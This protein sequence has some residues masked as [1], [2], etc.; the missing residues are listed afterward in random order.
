MAYYIFLRLYQRVSKY[1]YG[2]RPRTNNMTKP[3]TKPPSP[4]K[5]NAPLGG[6]I[7]SFGLSLASRQD[8]TE[9]GQWLQNKLHAYF[10]TGL[11]PGDMDGATGPDRDGER[12]RELFAH[13]SVLRDLL[14]RLGW[15]AGKAIK[16]SNYQ[17]KAL[18]LNI[19]SRAHHLLNI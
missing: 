3:A 10:V 14:D 18:A 4:P 17:T 1:N 8:W 11:R 12:E 6:R 2:S 9:Y 16:N 19:F 15:K 13:E 7:M 5:S